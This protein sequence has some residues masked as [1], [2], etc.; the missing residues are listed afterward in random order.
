MKHRAIVMSREDN[1]ATALED[2]VANCAVGVRDGAELKATILKEEIPFGHKFAT[3]T[4]LRGTSVI[5]YGQVIGAATQD[6]QAGA[7][8]HVHNVE[9]L[10][11]RGDKQ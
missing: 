1:V 6:I 4:I 8:A 11:G 2:L 3:E 7:H 5:K 9:S 10:R